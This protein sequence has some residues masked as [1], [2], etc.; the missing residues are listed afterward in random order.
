MAKLFWKYGKN[1]IA[2]A[3]V[4]YGLLKKMALIID[5]KDL[6]ASLNTNADEFCQ[7]AETML[8][9]CKESNKQKTM[10]ML[11]I[12]V[13]D[14]G[15]ATCRQIA[16]VTENMSFVAHPF[17]Q[18]VLS[19]EWMGKLFLQNRWTWVRMPYL[20][21]CY[22]LQGIQLSQDHDLIAK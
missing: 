9:K 18:S 3:L 16:L 14:L 15:N 8:S 7:L 21:I 6:E 1:Q 2:A 19:E 5:N 11:E 20:Y 4:A 13:E 17:F 10:D 22:N 12:K